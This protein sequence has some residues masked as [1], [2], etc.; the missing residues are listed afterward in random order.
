MTSCQS[1]PLLVFWPGFDHYPKISFAVKPLCETVLLETEAAKKEA[2]E[3][4]EAKT[5][6]L[7][8]MRK[9]EDLGIRKS[10]ANQANGA[11]SSEP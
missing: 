4:A 11:G 5:E 3:E 2:L 9:L 10:S 8:L 1:A 7:S 6:A